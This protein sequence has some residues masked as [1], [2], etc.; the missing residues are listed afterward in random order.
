VEVVSTF[1][2]ELEHHFHLSLPP[3]EMIRTLADKTL[4]QEFAE[5]EGFPVPRAIVLL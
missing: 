4:F 1:R 3:E 2:K 5:R